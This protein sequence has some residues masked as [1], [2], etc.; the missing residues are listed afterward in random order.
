M[1]LLRNIILM[2]GLL[3]LLPFIWIGRWLADEDH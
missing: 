2:F 3:C 1:N